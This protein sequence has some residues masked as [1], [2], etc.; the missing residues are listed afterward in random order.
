MPV[1]PHIIIIVIHEIMIINFLLLYP[2]FGLASEALSVVIS[3]LTEDSAKDDSLVVS[4]ISM[5]LSAKLSV[6]FSADIISEPAGMSDTFSVRLLPG[7]YEEPTSGSFE[8]SYP[9]ST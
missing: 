1:P 5:E 7:V 4:A 2:V 3:F 6:G 9:L 8:F